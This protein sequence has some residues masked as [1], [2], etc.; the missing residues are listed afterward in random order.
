MSSCVGLINLG[1]LDDS[2]FPDERPNLRRQQLGYRVALPYN[3]RH[4]SLSD[5]GVDAHGGYIDLS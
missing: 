2:T 3:G 5:A 4:S 1:K